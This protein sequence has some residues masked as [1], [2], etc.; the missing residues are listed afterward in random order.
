LQHFRTQITGTG[1]FLPPRIVT[2]KELEAQLKTTDQ[3]IQEKIGIK[4]RRYVDKGVGTSDLA[5]EAAKKALEAAGKKVGDIDCIIAATSTPDYCAPGIGV[6]IQNK[7]GCHKIPA[8][9]VHNASPGFIFSLELGDSLIRS[10]KYQCI[11]IVAAEVHSTALDFSEKGRLM[12]V[13]F[14]D[15][16]GAVVLEPTESKHGILGTRLHSDGAYFDKLWCEAPSSLHHPRL[17]KEMI[18]EGK[19]FPTMDGRVVFEN[20][21]HLM[22]LVAEEVLVTHNH[23]VNDISF[24][25][26]HQA[27]LRIIEA[28]AKR[29]EV[30]MDKV[31]RNIENVGNTNAAT[32]PILL[33]EAVRQ[34]RIK[35]GD[36][37]L[38]MSFGSGFSWGSALIRW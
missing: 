32:I 24:V 8:Y 33:D 25:L 5:V 17:T 7:L 12:S 13:I 10:G 23:S 27:N 1:S 9:D 16:A 3:W 18:D 11:L 14:G 29:L 6:L 28:I 35:E 31:L 26:P 36:L 38:S 20:A 2:N 37:L 34:K 21:V 22:S 15:G 30:P 19:I 4:Q